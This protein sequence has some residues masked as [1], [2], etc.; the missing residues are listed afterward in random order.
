MESI[1]FG[2]NKCTTD[3]FTNTR[4]VTNITELK[5]IINNNLQTNLTYYSKC[6]CWRDLNEKL[7]KLTNFFCCRF[8][9]RDEC[10][11]TNTGCFLIDKPED[12]TI[13]N[14]R[15]QRNNQNL[16]DCYYENINKKEFFEIIKPG[17]LVSWMHKTA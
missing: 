15:I 7:K 1:H 17:S 12:E 2:C 9:V 3:E 16:H 6:P 10:L 11:I 14:Y 8:M 5:E 13:N 4:Y